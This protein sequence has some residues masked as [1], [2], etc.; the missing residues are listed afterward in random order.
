[1]TNTK[2]KELLAKVAGQSLKNIEVNVG[3][4]PVTE[5]YFGEIKTLLK[6]NGFDLATSEDDF[7]FYFAKW[8]DW[9]VV[10]GIITEIMKRFKWIAERADCD[11]RADLVS[12]LVSVIFK[13]NTCGNVRCKTYNK[14]TGKT[15]LHR[16]NLIIDWAGDTYLYDIDN[17]GR[18]S[19]AENEKVEMGDKTYTEFEDAQYH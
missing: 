12:A 13:L 15:F 16:C 19:R 8:E 10:L 17:G 6:N 7:N 1:M 2:I 11:N 5:K 9:K 4:I 3:E 18:Y 14:K